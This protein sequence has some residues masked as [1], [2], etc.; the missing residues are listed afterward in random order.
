MT[1]REHDGELPQGWCSATIPDLIG[2]DGE[3]TD[4]DWV[5]SKDQDP[6]GAI[7]LTQL[8]DVGDGIF[9]DR[10]RRYLT[11]QKSEELRCTYLREGDVLIARMP[12]PLGRA[13]LF[14]KIEQ[15]CVTVVD[16]C[17]VRPGEG[18]IDPRWLM[19]I[20]N[21]PQIRSA[22]ASHQSGTTRKRISKKNLSRIKIP[23]APLHEQL[24]IAAAADSA[25]SKLDFAVAGLKRAQANLKRYRASVLQ[26]AVEGRLVPTEAELACEEGR[27]YEPAE[28]LLDR[29]LAERR[30]R[31]EEAELERLQ[32]KGRL[33]TN[34]NWRSKYKKLAAPAVQDLPELPDGWC[35]S[36]VGQL[37]EVS[38]GLTKNAKREAHPLQMPY[39][40]VANVYS[41]RLELDEVKE[42]GVRD[43]E[44][45]KVLLQAGDLLVVEGNGSIDQIG[46]VAL[47]DGTVPQCVHQ[48]H[49]IKVRFS[50]VGIGRWVLAWLLSPSGRRHIVKVA[51]STSGLHTLSVS[52]VASLPVPVPP[53]SEQERILSEIDMMMSVA[54]ETEKGMQ[55]N[56]KRCD[57]LRQSVL[58]WAFAGRLVCQH[59]G[60]EPAEVILDRLREELPEKTR[61]ARRKRA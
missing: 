21:S 28:V 15:T 38:G 59:P 50:P 29:I 18:S 10:S 47:W 23:I 36:T 52:K 20:I 60:D 4:G 55:V 3:L 13:C 42:I 24:R 6:E 37:G 56:L 1:T 16:V 43:S 27:D 44:L 17:V 61:Q 31:W 5:E 9:R 53:V 30:H 12:D 8:A 54:V 41:N 14:P 58:G 25:L 11:Q 7:R 46:R 57:R 33:P 35:W 2:V 26:S 51:S 49:L 40:R 48:N 45:A 22:V 39:L 34:D 19:H 32:A